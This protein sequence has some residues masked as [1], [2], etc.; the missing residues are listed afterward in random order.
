MIQFYFLSIVLNAA[1]GYILAFSTD[2]DD[3]DVES[4][5]G[6]L[7]HKESFRLILGVLTILTGLLK[8]LSAVEGD[9]P[10]IGDLIP[11][12]VG[13]LAGFILIFEYYRSRSALDPEHTEK[14]EQLLISNKKWV[15]F[16]A[17][18]SA[19]LH[20]LFPTVLLL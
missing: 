16:L 8:I 10:V 7:L 4:K 19:I 1:S 13:F 11:A 18:A 14:I 9:V 17:I 2:N 20:F 15:G 3:I 12:L 6:I 5:V